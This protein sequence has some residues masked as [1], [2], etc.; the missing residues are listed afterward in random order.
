MT[1][2]DRPSKR[3]HYLYPFAIVG[4]ALLWLPPIGGESIRAQMNNGPSREAD[5]HIY[6]FATAQSGS[7]DRVIRVSADLS[8]VKRLDLDAQHSV[9]KLVPPGDRIVAIS[10][11]SLDSVNT[12]KPMVQV[13]DTKKFTVT[14]RQPFADFGRL[15][16]SAKGR[17]ITSDV[18]PNMVGVLCSNDRKS[19]LPEE[20]TFSVRVMS[21]DSGEGKS[22][23]VPER[24]RLGDFF[25]TSTRTLAIACYSPTN[26]VYAIDLATGD[27][28]AGWTQSLAQDVSKETQGALVSEPLLLA[29]AG[30]LG[31][32]APAKLVGLSRSGDRRDLSLGGSQPSVS[33]LV[34]P[35]TGERLRVDSV[36]R[37]KD[38][39]FTA[40]LVRSM[41]EEGTTWRIEVFDDQWRRQSTIAEG[42][43]LWDCAF[44]PNANEVVALH[45]DGTLSVWQIANGSVIRKASKIVP[46]AANSWT[47]EPAF[48]GV[49]R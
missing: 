32:D 30:F 7:T 24:M 39:R 22:Y 13:I 44:G 10:G 16:G 29:E 31:G 40:L 25:L 15:I 8:E 42:E 45:R 33:R 11:R 19:G 23:A 17:V 38:Q 47:T 4:L 2:L 48:I 1:H 28:I 26:R 12:D 49:G 9:A 20:T 3:T 5:K 37:S 14:S 21:L 41:R 27:F 43:Q 36:A 46:E 18:A 6:L 34:A 35:G